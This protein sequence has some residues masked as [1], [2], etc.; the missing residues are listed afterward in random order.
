MHVH[1]ANYTSLNKPLLIV[2]IR[3]SALQTH[4]QNLSMTIAYKT[5]CVYDVVFILLLLLLLFCQ[6]VSP[7][8][9]PMHHQV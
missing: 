9:S 2:Y 1:E 3:F 4:L 5:K 7:D 6:N 8:S